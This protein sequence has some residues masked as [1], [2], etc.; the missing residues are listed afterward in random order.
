MLSLE[1]FHFPQINQHECTE[2]LKHGD[3]QDHY[4]SFYDEEKSESNIFHILSHLV[5]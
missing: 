1:Y 4:L 3:S 2:V 5:V